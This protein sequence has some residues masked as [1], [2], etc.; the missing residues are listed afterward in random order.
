MMASECA[1]ARRYRPVIC[2]RDSPAVAHMSA[3]GSASSSS[4]GSG[5]P[6]GRPKQSPKY[7]SSTLATCLISPSR[8]VPV[9]TIGRRMLYS[10]SPSSFHSKASRAS[11][12]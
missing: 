7:P 9:G 3:L 12:R 1:Q 2:S 8:L 10:E 5:S 4:H 11:C 6:N